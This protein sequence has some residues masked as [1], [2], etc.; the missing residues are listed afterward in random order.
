MKV[1]KIIF[2]NILIFILVLAITEISILSYKVFVKKEYNIKNYML[3]N[4]SMYDD[5]RFDDSDNNGGSGRL[6]DKNVNL[7]NPSIVIFGCSF[8]YGQYLKQNQIFSYKLSQALN[9]PVYNRARSG[10]G[11]NFMYYQTTKDSFYN[12]IPKPD[13][14]IYVMI[15]DIFRR[16]Y[17]TMFGLNDIEYVLR[18]KKTVSLN[19]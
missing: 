3:G 19:Y 18:Y 13:T 16:M 5:F 1:F 10:M 12:E 9:C 7:N 4:Y 11:L 17:T 6:P 15:D 2:I 14:V 8:A